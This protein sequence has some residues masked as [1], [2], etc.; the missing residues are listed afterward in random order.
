MLK[1]LITTLEIIIDNVGMQQRGLTPL[2][3]NPILGDFGP[4]KNGPKSGF[5]GMS[6]P[7]SQPSVDQISFFYEIVQKLPILT[8]RSPGKVLLSIGDD[9]RM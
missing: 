2:T 7:L 4:P 3:R 8:S 9:I 1:H 5:F 6:G